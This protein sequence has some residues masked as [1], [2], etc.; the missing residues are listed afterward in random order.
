MRS[1]P[2]PSS[3]VPE[4]LSRLWRDFVDPPDEARPRVWWHWMD[5]N[6]DPAGIVRDLTWLHDVGV[7][8]VQLFDG[9]MGVPLVV[10]EPVRPGTPAWADAIDTAVRTADAL[11]LE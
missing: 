5:G 10:P 7:R 8:G 4:P 11:D 9:G 6:I 1:V 3:S 2:D